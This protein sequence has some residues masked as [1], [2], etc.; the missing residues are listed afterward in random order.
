MPMIKLL[1]TCYMN[2]NISTDAQAYE[3]CIP[4]KNLY[5]LDKKVDCENEDV[6][7]HLN[8]IAEVMMEWASVAP[9]LRL[10]PIEVDDIE[11]SHQ[12]KRR[13]LVLTILVRGGPQ[14]CWSSG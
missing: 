4:F 9:L 5:K 2:V 14:S 1:A 13:R 8:K 3:K 12:P 11:V 7:L 10:T 6:D